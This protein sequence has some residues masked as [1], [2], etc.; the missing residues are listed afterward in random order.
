MRVIKKQTLVRFWQSHP[1]AEPPLRTWLAIAS[2]ATWHTPADIKAFDR[3]ASFVARNRIVFN[4]GGHRFR[5]IACVAYDFQAMYIKFIGTHT[6]YDKI[7]AATVD[8][9]Y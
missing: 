9:E 2:R 8:M 1:P 6:E 5:L 7:D 4:I 3:S